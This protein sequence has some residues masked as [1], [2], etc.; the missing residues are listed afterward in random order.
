MSKKYGIASVAEPKIQVALA[1]QAI[2]AIN[3][4]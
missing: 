1:V 3:M 4:V 2:A